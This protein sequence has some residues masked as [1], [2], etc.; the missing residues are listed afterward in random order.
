[1]S[2]YLESLSIVV[3]ECDEALRQVDTA[4]VER[5]IE[6]LLLAERIFFVGTGRV[7]LSLQS[8]STRLRHIGLET[9]HVGQTGEPPISERDLLIIGSGSGESIF[10]VA[11]AHRAKEIGVRIVHIGSNP[12]S[13]LR[14]VT[15]LFVRI[16]ARTK[17]NRTDEID[18]RQPM[19]SLFEQSL[20]LFGDV[21]ANMLIQRKG[22]SSATLW[23]HHANL[24]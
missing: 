24:E 17:L 4:T 12:E 16:P 7:M 1:M 23:S 11:V 13:S 15:D 5:F 22:L 6:S 8:M 18:S 19:S 20:L 9:Y 14:Q 2:Q 21:V 3:N 10:P